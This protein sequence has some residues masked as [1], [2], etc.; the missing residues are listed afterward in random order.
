MMRVI[1]ATLV[2][3]SS[4]V[5]F[6]G[7]ASAEDLQCPAAIGS[8]RLA[9]DP[10]RLSVSGRVVQNPN[11]APGLMMAGC[12]YVTSGFDPIRGL[13]GID[14]APA[15]QVQWR[16]KAG[17]D[18]ASAY[19]CGQF[20]PPGMNV[21]FSPK[22]KRAFAVWDARDHPEVAAQLRALALSL[23]TQVES[24]A[25]ACG[26]TATATP[27]A[28]TRATGGAIDITF[29][30]ALTGR[31]TELAAPAQCAPDTTF[32][33]G[34]Y[35]LIFKARL[36]N[37]VYELQL[38]GPKGT[39]TPQKFVANAQQIRVGGPSV[40]VLGPG[41]ST[42][43]APIPGTQWS[44]STSGGGSF[45]IADDLSGSL[46]VPLGPTANA[47]AGSP[48]LR[49][50]GTFKC[51]GTVVVLPP[52]GGGG[53]NSGDSGGS[54][55]DVDLVATLVAAGFDPETATLIAEAVDEVGLPLSSA[56]VAVLGALIASGAATGAATA[57]GTLAATGAAASGILDPYTGQR[58]TAWQPGKY[59]AGSDGRAGSAGDV[60]FQGR[61]VKPDF[62]RD[63]IAASLAADRQRD[64]ESAAFAAGTAAMVEQW[65][66]DKGLEARQEEWLASRR[67]EAQIA[68]GNITDIAIRRGLAYD[69]V[70]DRLDRAYDDRGRID[71]NYVENLRSIMRAR[72]ARDAAAPDESLRR[73]GQAFEE[74]VSQTA[75][76][77]AHNPIIN[78][79]LG[80]LTGGAGTAAIMAFHAANVGLQAYDAM[81]AAADQAAREG[82]DLGYTDAMRAAG[83]EIS[84][85]YL[86]RET[87][88][89]WQRANDPNKPEPTT[90]EIIS[91]VG[92]DAMTVA[93][94]G[95]SAHET[96]EAFQ[97]GRVPPQQPLR[98]IRADPM[99]LTLRIPE[100]PRGRATWR[101]PEA[102]PPRLPRDLPV[103]SAPATPT[104]HAAPGTHRLAPDARALERA[105]AGQA[106]RPLRNIEEGTVLTR[107][108][109]GL[110]Q[111]ALER[112]RQ[113]A[114][115]HP[116]FEV[117]YR[118]T[119]EGARLRVAVDG[120]AFKPP[121][122]HAK[123]INPTDTLIGAPSEH[124]NR[125]AIFEPISEE[126]LRGVLV[127]KSPEQI[128]EIQSRWRQR[129]NEFNDLRPT[130]N[131]KIENGRFSLDHTG[132]AGGAGKGGVVLDGAALRGG[133][134]VHFTGDNDILFYRYRDPATG[135]LARPPQAWID[136]HQQ[137]MRPYGVQ[138]PDQFSFAWPRDGS[139]IDKSNMDI[140]RT[141]IGAH[142]PPSAVDASLSRVEAARVGD[143]NPIAV[144]DS[145]T[146]TI[147]AEYVHESGGIAPLTAPEPVA[148][149]LEE[150]RARQL[151]VSG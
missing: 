12:S 82:R 8:L 117:G 48:A 124:L 119:S 85:N 116:G 115:E 2:A 143:G 129:M 54:A 41:A 93:G 99:D 91:A 86:P 107:R 66:I 55:G 127:G 89:L 30:G 126:Q 25:L 74:F 23:V 43:G 81:S 35:G 83:R 103:R 65:A 71:P 136:E 16:E 33:T 105:D 7:V 36:G 42:S 53:G 3:L 95:R 76:D 34:L 92:S 131:E 22:G 60:W 15:V 141:I 63:E 111:A 88:D 59:G 26:A 56:L 139:A 98:V 112:E 24:R 75:S 28:T 9:S 123:T 137:A 128:V 100:P 61:W 37:Q 145:R 4:L 80:I 29:S 5:L 38:L 50:S 27:G 146:S 135:A 1:A 147:R 45:T 101:V 118:P 11:G 84:R 70:Y 17:T 57:A 18:D 19:E 121:D 67:R 31:L 109:V 90:W 96:Y 108:D 10:N 64:A 79:G 47:P 46:D 140:H 142:A 122:L 134:R 49:V 32:G 102:D 73:P 104:D 87:Y 110:T 138:H 44:S 106:P 130:F 68:L 6:G 125:A 69:D 13:G 40:N 72:L 114:R 148:P 62:A 51:T 78:A 149:R 113:F 133:E 132:F 21:V 20:T 94:M 151:G 39:S 144:L 150:W 97:A 77:V 52:P 58:L 120:D 14:T